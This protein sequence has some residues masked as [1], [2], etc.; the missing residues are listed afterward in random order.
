M[1]GCQPYSAGRIALTD[2]FVGDNSYQAML[3]VV[4]MS[5]TLGEYQERITALLPPG[6]DVAAA[7][8]QGVVFLAVQQ[9]G[10]YDSTLDVLLVMVSSALVDLDR[11]LQDAGFWTQVKRT[12]TRLPSGT[13]SP[14]LQIQVR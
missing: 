9:A 14:N 5:E 8:N 1:I 4:D 13:N 12:L 3:N 11:R 6:T 7:D 10:A 2:E